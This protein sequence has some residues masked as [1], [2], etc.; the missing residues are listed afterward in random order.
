MNSTGRQSEK[1]S[2]LVILLLMVGLTAFSHSMKELTEIHNLTLDASR[3]IAQWSGNV[4]PAE[5]L[6][7]PVTIVKVEKLESCESKQS[8]PP[9]ELRWLKKAPEQTEPSA[10]APAPSRS[11]PAS[12]EA[13]SW[14]EIHFP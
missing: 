1:S 11:S 12:G 2:Y 5:I 3:L 6:Q 7:T 10:V 8:A 4:T 13:L 9:V 14:Q